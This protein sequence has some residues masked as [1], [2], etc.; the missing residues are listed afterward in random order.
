MYISNLLGLFVGA[1]VNPFFKTFSSSSVSVLPLKLKIP[2]CVVFTLCF[3]PLCVPLHVGCSTFSVLPLPSS[4]VVLMV[5]WCM[6]GDSSK[7]CSFPLLPLFLFFC[8]FV[9]F[10]VICSCVIFCVPSLKNSPLVGYF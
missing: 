1:N 9:L 5:N 7:H 3:F 6:L 10:L 8:P 2:F 4:G